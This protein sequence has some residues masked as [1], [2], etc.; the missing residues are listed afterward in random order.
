V[1]TSG[2]TEA[3]NLALFGLAG[4][5]PGRVVVSAIEHPSVLAAADRL[6]RRGWH[7][8][9]LRASIDGVVDLEQLRA[10]LAA[11]AHLVSLMWGNNETGALQPIAE[12]A[13]I[14]R[15]AGVPLHSD[16]VQV[17]GKLPIEFDRLGASAVSLAAHK[18]HG[19]RGIGALVVDSA[20]SL[21]GQLCGGFQQQGLRPGTESIELAIGMCWALELWASEA[22]ERHR[23]LARLRD[24]FESRLRAGR[25][26][27]VV[28]GSGAPRLPHTS[29]V[30]FVGLDRQEL[31]MALDLAGVQC[32]TGSACASG[33]SEP[34]PV[35]RAMGLPDSIVN[36][37][38]RFSLGANTTEADIDE[39]ATRI[40]Q[41][42]NDLEGSK[43]GRK[44][45]VTPPA[46]TANSL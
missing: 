26:D 22:D 16:A 37:A 15:A 20:V 30:S 13:E 44:I 18:F 21:E 27:L 32:S 39:A 12:A 45:A 5:T 42:C 8:V 46:R 11:P 35:L 2:G 41:V 4:E 17:V 25:G 24:R 34:S 29:N 7:V 6:A 19:P 10:A 31:F 28:N 33:S 3:N 38:L 14:C 9:R 40:L 1:L 23:R 36:S 43:G